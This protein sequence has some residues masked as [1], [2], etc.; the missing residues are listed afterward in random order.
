MSRDFADWYQS[1]SFNHNHDVQTLREEAAKAAVEELSNEAALDLVRFLFGGPVVNSD[2]INNFRKYFK[3]KDPA[4]KSTGNDQEVLVLTGWVLAEHC[5]TTSSP[6]TVAILTASACGTRKP[7]IEADIVGIAENENIRDG[8][9][10]RERCEIKISEKLSSEDADKITDVD[11]LKSYC[12]TLQTQNIELATSV[13]SNMEVQDEELQILW[14]LIGGLSNMWDAPFES[15]DTKARPFL[16]GHEL[17]TISSLQVEPR[18]IR[19]I[20][21]KAKITDEQITISEAVTTCK[22]QLMKLG[23]GI[24]PCSI[25]TPVHF[26]IARAC[27]TDGDPSWIVPWQ[28]VTGINADLPITAL[29]LAIQYFRERKLLDELNE[30]V[31]GK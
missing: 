10:T 19:S 24:K 30:K 26:A 6:A 15:I 16:L 12:E 2:Q 18:S 11:T 9:N 14:W 3:D 1:V 17:A 7:L 20:L 4:F 28:K 21:S 25:I 8:D 29:D 27:E 22:A 31:E 5:T 23:M 13:R